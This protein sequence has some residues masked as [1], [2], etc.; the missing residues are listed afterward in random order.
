MLVEATE[1]LEMRK[2]SARPEPT[3]LLLSRLEAAYALGISPRKFDYLVAEK[4]IQVRRIGK[5]VLVSRAALE[6]FASGR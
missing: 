3:R 1:D 2:L 6:R 4:A 5:R